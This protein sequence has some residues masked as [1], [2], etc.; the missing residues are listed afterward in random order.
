MK[1][2]LALALITMAALT[3]G[4]AAVRAPA[5]ESAP[6]DTVDEALVN[7]KIDARLQQ[8]LASA[9][10]DRARARAMRASR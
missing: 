2:M 3:A 7:A 6:A 5:A 1:K 10:A 9:L 4:G 8:R